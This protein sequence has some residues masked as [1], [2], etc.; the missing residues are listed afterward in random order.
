MKRLLRNALSGKRWNSRPES[1]D[2]QKARSSERWSS[3]TACC[4][5]KKEWKRAA[6]DMQRSFV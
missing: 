6:P 3:R 2:L 5:S 4:E 1:Q